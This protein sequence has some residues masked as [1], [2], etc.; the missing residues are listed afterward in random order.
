MEKKKQAAHLDSPLEQDAD[1]RMTLKS[2]P[3][4]RRKRILALI[5]AIL[6]II[7]TIAYTYSL[8]TGSFL[9]W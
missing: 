8:A 4:P 6:M 5:G 2:S 1:T 7:L 3:T 9:K